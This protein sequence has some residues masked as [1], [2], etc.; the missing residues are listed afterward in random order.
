VLLSYA[1]AQAVAMAIVDSLNTSSKRLS[2]DLVV[3]AY[4]DD[5]TSNA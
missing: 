2:I 4:I 3:F 5:L 1:K